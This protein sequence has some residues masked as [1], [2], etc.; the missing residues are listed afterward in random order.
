LTK[1]ISLLTSKQ[2]IFAYARLTDANILEYLQE[3]DK[4]QSHG[5]GY[6]VLGILSGLGVAKNYY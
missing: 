6:F 5:S 2:E 4:F 1:C 3:A